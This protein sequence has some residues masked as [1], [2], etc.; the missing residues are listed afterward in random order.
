VYGGMTNLAEAGTL[1]MEFTSIGR[2]TGREEFSNAG[3]LTWYQIQQ[4]PN[5]DGLY[6]TGFNADNMACTDS[7]YGFGAAADSAYEYMLKQ[8]VL[9]AG[10]DKV[11]SAPP[12]PG[13]PAA[14]L[15]WQRDSLRWRGWSPGAGRPELFPEQRGT[16]ARLLT[17]PCPLTLRPAHPSCHLPLPLPR[18][19]GA[20]TRT[21]STACAS[22]WSSAWT[23]TATTRTPSRT[24]RVS[25]W[26]PARRWRA[27]VLDGAAAGMG[28][29]GMG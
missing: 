15:R 9:S 18:C 26:G 27:A 7:K 29:D 5:I 13:R 20:C 12:P 10:Q 11:R 25:G 23:T 19:A 4:M 22:T 3:M 1:S 24:S 8:W 2:L 14:W 16:M 17:A 28:W 6:C 21:P